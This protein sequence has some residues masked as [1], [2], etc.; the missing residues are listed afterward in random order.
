R[1]SACILRIPT[2]ACA[3]K[4]EHSVFPRTSAAAI[5]YSHLRWTMPKKH[6]WLLLLLTVTSVA[7]ADDWHKEYAIQDKP[8]LR[9]ETGDAHVR[10]VPWDKKS[11]DITVTTVN[12]KIGPGHLEIAESQTRDTV[13]F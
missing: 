1:P 7:F 13:D 4:I 6:L 8:D 9:V 10:V 11:I 2:G 12:W 5:A 3:A